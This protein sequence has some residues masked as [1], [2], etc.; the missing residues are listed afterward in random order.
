MYDPHDFNSP[1]HPAG[2]PP[3]VDVVPA[4]PAALVFAARP[5]GAHPAS[6]PVFPLIGMHRRAAGADILLVIAMMLVIMVSPAMASLMMLLE[7]VS[8]TYGPLLSNTV[9]GG[10]VVFLVVAIL[11][12]RKQ[13]PNRIGLNRPTM[14]HG[15][16]G[17]AAVPACYFAIFLTGILYVLFVG[18]DVEALVDEKKALIDI[19]PEFS[20]TTVLLFGV[21]TGFFEELLFRGLFLTRFNALVRNRAL[22]VILA[23]LLFGL[24]HVYQGPMG[25]VQTAAIGV[26]LGA[27]ATLAR[28]L[29]PAI[30]AHAAFNSAQFAL[31]P[32]AAKMLDE[33]SRQAATMPS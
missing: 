27:V 22:A 1:S 10:C 24:V 23:A 20:L 32:L 21:F 29:W 17:V 18:E 6:I 13:W 16:L 26:I 28:S 11:A 9:I 30:I 4:R 14:L 19:V 3:I 12:L 33:L 25:M 5:V 31:M 2:Q 8:P 7:Q 15:L